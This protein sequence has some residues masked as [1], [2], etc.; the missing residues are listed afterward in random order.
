APEELPFTFAA[1][2]RRARDVWV[3][4]CGAGIALVSMVTMARASEH[5]SR[6]GET[7]WDSKRDCLVTHGPVG[8]LSL[9]SLGIGLVASALAFASWWIA[10]AQSV[11][12]SVQ[13][14]MTAASG[15]LAAS[16]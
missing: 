10:P 12:A 7:T 2:I 1:A 16:R 4:G 8:T 13:R 11:A 5:I 9:L 6:S 15:R 3:R 14:A